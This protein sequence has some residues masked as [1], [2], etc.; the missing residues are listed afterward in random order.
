MALGPEDIE[1]I[2]Q[3]IREEVRSAF[4]PS[5]VSTPSWAD[6]VHEVQLHLEQLRQ[7]SR[8]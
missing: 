3:I 7:R 4:G 6:K 1:K 5:I 2:R 8:E